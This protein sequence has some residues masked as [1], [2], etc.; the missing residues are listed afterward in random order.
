MDFIDDSILEYAQKHSSPESDLLKEI[1]RQT[2]LE[3]L[4]PRMLS[5]YLQGRFLALIAKM[6]KPLRILEIGTYTGYSALCMAE[7]LD[8]KGIL[9]TIDVNDELAVKTQQN[10][11]KSQFKEQIRLLVGKAQQI[12]PQM[13]EVFDLVFIDADKKNYALYFDLV[14][15]KVRSGGMIIADNVLW[16]GK[17]I[18]PEVKP[19]KDTLNMIEFN[20]KIT[21][22]T[23]V[24]NLLL[25]IRDGLMMMVKI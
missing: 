6:L 7:G 8:T 3:V 1:E 15:D 22:D 13:N 21:E 14:I 24:D 11:D 10:F 25:P 23:R 5:G 4:M 16:S 18:K 2:H 20:K 17:V 9:Y 12:I 19:D